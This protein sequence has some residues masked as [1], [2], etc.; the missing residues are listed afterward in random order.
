MTPPPPTPFAVHVSQLLAVLEA[1]EALEAYYSAFTAQYYTEL[2]ALDALEVAEDPLDAIEPPV[3]QRA[4]VVASRRAR[5]LRQRALRQ[6]V[7]RQRVR[8]TRE[9]TAHRRSHSPKSHANERRDAVEMLRERLEREW[10][11]DLAYWFW[12]NGL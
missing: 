7:L 5:G 3:S 10:E 4:R 12:R 2:E 11:L 9:Y 8:E 6:E 1:S